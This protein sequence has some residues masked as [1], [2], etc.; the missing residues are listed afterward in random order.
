VSHCDKTVADEGA[1]IRTRRGLGRLI[2]LAVGLFGFPEACSRQGTEPLSV[3]KQQAAW[4]LVAVNLPAA[5]LSIDGRS[6]KD[7]FAV[8]ADKG[9]GPLVLHFDG[10]SWLELP[11]GQRG[12]LW[13][14]HA[15]PDGTALM[16][17]SSAMV[18]RF[19]RGKFDRLLPDG[20]FARQTVYGIWGKSTNDFYAVGS[21]AGRD[22]FIWHYENG[23]FHDEPLPP[24]LPLAS[25]GQPPGFFKVWGHD[26]DVWVVGA[27]GS[28]L[29]RNGIERFA[30]V[31]SGKKDTFFT[32][33]GIGD[34]LLM[35]GGGSNGMVLD[36]S[37]GSLHDI[38]PPD[39]PLIQGVYLTEKGDWASG[40]RGGIYTR[41]GSEP[42]HSVEHGL[43]MPVSSSLHAI[44]VDSAQGVWAVG[45]NVL[46]P[47]LDG[48]ILVHFGR[49]IPEVELH[50]PK[51][52]APATC[53]K[54]IVA[55]GRDKS[56]ARRWDEQALAS[57]R[58]DLPRP[59]IH[60]RNLF[61]LSV[62]MWDAWAAYDD[63]AAG[64]FVREKHRADDVNGAQRTAISYAAFGVLGHRY[65]PAIGGDRTLACLTAVMSDLGYDPA[66]AHDQGDD[67]V[68]L[69]NR[70]AHRLVE[71][72]ANDGANESEDYTDPKPFVSPNPPLIYDNPG[73]S[74]ID[75]NVWQPLNLSIAATQNG[76]V[77][78]AGVQDYVGSQW[79]SVT[80]FAL[81]RA[82]SSAPWTDIGKAPKVGPAMKGWIAEIIR[83][84]SELDPADG[85]TIDISPGAYGHNSLGANDGTG[86]RVNPVTG[87]PYEPQ[88]VPRADFARVMAEFWADGPKS[89]TPPG[90]WNVLANQVSDSPDFVRRLFGRGP[91][92]DPMSWDI[93]TYLALN[94]AE[95]DAALA[96]WD[97]KRRTVSSRPIALI[98]WM[99]AKGQSSNPSGP[100]Y[101]AE[102]LPLIPGLIEVITQESSAPGQ[103]HERL[104][105]Y[106]GQIAVRGW[107][108]EPADRTQQNSG[109]GWIR[110]TDWVP[111][112]RRNF[113]TPAF[114][115]YISGHSTF[116]RAGAEV[117]S[118]LTGSPYFPGGLAEFVAPASTFLTFE[119]GPTKTVRLQW[120]SYS[121][122]SDEAGQS[123]LWGGI[124]IVP[125]DFVGRRI[126][127]RVGQSAVAKAKTYY[128][129]SAK[130]VA[131]GQPR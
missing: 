25:L 116:S 44:Y 9:E 57:I 28:V 121:D 91:I 37:R 66:D 48:G 77:L 120:A 7:V 113:V 16:G 117:L 115:G 38:S 10:S 68:A 98:R 69:G 51:A 82:S 32:V 18:L 58:L 46:S 78:P 50:A 24:D 42:F 19:A 86:W 34:R 81:K 102:G 85:A 71:Q 93:H 97:G 74:T 94:G 70:V 54:E 89:E 122:A 106:V 83:K 100:S 84:E 130:G 112:Q 60:A 125:D 108:G 5:L 20:C 79:G 61:H 55:A 33:N 62:A 104:A 2:V 15:F 123:R 101:D 3:Q 118:I 96:A 17:G 90:H 23:S 49:A 92:V 72:A 30:L 56:I 114:P 129:G 39:V 6:D 45:G 67:P 63:Q 27:S 111:Y 31:P 43:P 103:R 76:I 12:D 47:A 75:P 64:I 52:A 88:I 1:S 87:K 36:S 53:P 35:V 119:K 8:G 14:V 41:K 110:A 73:T 131:T 11:T 26:G 40:E 59:P 4:Q 95:H 109:V 124:H 65:K 128:D 80:P 105:H 22:G 99:G 107:Q 126:G 13:W 21:V 29:H 127:S